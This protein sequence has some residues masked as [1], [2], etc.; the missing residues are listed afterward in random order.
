MAPEQASTIAQFLI[1]T[2]EREAETTRRVLAAVPADKMDFTPHPK[3]MP[4]AQ[5]AW[6]VASAEVFFLNGIADGQFKVKLMEQPE[7]VK[8]PADI[9]A[10][11][12]AEAKKA[13]D[14]LKNL[15]A[16]A[17]SR[18]VSFAV[19]QRPAIEYLLMSTAHMIHHRG[20]LSVY[21]RLMGASV[22]SIYGP[23]ADEPPEAEEKTASA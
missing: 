6:H 5:L 13:I 21:L 10:W 7:S 19:F 18:I 11:H 12:A 4:A 20:Q 1:S 15:P 2:A 8:T 16:E 9:V 14:R 17:W 23:S 3:N 22:P